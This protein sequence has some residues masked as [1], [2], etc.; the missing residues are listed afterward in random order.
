MTYWKLSC[1][2]FAMGSSNCLLTICGSLECLCISSAQIHVH[3]LGGDDNSIQ[4][5]R[6]V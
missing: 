3:E 6:I 1:A 5:S 4:V 2:C